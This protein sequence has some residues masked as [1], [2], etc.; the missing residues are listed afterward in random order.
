MIA[1]RR[2]VQPSRT[3]ATLAPALVATTEIRLAPTAICIGMCAR[4]TSPGTMKTPP[5]KP[6][7]APTKPA[8]IE[9]A[10]SPARMVSTRYLPDRQASCQL[11][12]ELPLESAARLNWD[13]HLGCDSD[14]HQHKTVRNRQFK[15]VESRIAGPPEMPGPRA[16]QLR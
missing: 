10:K 2:L 7:S 9:S 3:N 15:P 8:P 14:S 4:M 5:P 11:P 12:L 6:D 13:L 16:G 1:T